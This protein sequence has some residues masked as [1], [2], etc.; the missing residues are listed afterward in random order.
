M[1]LKTIVTHSGSF[2]ADEALAVYMLKKLPEYATCPI[3]RTRDA[4]VI[5]QGLV[6]VDV[7]GE[8]IPESHRYDHH[9]RGFEITYSPKHDIKL[10]S[11]GLVYKHF[12]ERV[13]ESILGHVHDQSKEI[14]SRWI[15]VDSGTFKF[16]LGSMI[17]SSLASMVLITVCQC[18]PPM[19]LQNIKSQLQFLLVF[20]D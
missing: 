17:N 1:S 18:I 3:V 14:V 13:I 4:A 7:G 9:Q 8:Y 11:A 19:S 15:F 5:A 16:D 2:H 6:V 10:S 20:L 12:G